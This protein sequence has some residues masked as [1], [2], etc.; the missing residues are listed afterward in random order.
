[1]SK[2]YLYK[3]YW[4]I[5]L[6]EFRKSKTSNESIQGSSSNLRQQATGEVT[7]NRELNRR[8]AATKTK[9]FVKIFFNGK[10]VS[11]SIIFITVYSQLEFYIPFK[12]I[13]YLLLLFS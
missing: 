11:Y 13:K 3:V 6:F 7:D 2:Y 10:Q 9:L 12:R 4:L 1:M 8:N 5:F